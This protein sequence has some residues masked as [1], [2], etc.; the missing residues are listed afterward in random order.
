MNL[1]IIK[2]KESIL[3]IVISMHETLKN[4]GEI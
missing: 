4:R 1:T 2:L 3:V